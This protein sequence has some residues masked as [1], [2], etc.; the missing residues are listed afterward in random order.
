MQ[1]LISKSG[2]VHATLMRLFSVVFALVL[3]ACEAGSN[4]STTSTPV[5]STYTV[6]GTISGLTSG[7]LILKNVSTLNSADTLT[8]STNST[9]FTFATALASITPYNVTVVTQPSGLF[10]TVSN[11]S[12]FTANSNVTDVIVA[13]RTQFAYV[14]N[15]S[16]N[17]VSMY[18]INASTGLLT[19]LSPSTI[20]TGDA[21]YPESIAINPA[22]SFAYVT[23]YGGSS[24][25][26]YAINTS[27]G[28]LTPLSPSSISSA[29]TLSSIV[30]NSSGSFAYATSY[31]G[32]SVSMYAINASTGILTALST[33]IATEFGAN[34][35]TINP[36]GSF[37]YVANHLSST[38]S[39]YAINAS[40]G[41][42]TAS[43]TP[44]ATGSSPFSIA[45]NPAGSFA[46][47]V[48]GA[49][50][51]VSMYAINASTGILTP[52]STPD[53]TTGSPDSNPY[54]IAIDSSGSFAYVTNLNGMVSMYAI[55]ASTGLLTALDP[56]T[57]DA[58]GSL[59]SI[60]I[61]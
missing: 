18:A 14:V 54:S 21:N 38:V 44:I 20:T 33:P 4:S 25:S 23:S 29:G 15:E 1:Q 22:G 42:L 37:A 5:A 47:V 56:S 34:S 51:T 39:M 12:G 61:K 2:S 24:V 8:I 17:A 46:Y 13:C 50:N 40:T 49:S 35:I 41:I 58:L 10:C 30:I 60:A 9:T 57:I 26:M 11:G 7:S 48:N 53:I 28:I 6:G 16:L 31:G 45:I 55:N 36:A 3:V 32:S 52:L 19:A 59:R 27:T 43:G